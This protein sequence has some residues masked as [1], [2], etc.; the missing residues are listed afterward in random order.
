MKRR[1]RKEKDHHSL[2]SLRTNAARHQRGLC[3]W[4]GKPME[5]VTADHLVPLHA[6]GKTRPGNIVAACAPCNNE[7]HPELNQRVKVEHDK[8]RGVFA[9]IG[10]E[11]AS[12]PFA[13]LAQLK[14]S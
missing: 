3:Y 12:S 9:S 7:R 14:R 4:C 8:T 6:G 10:N 1:R 5:Q 11:T 13:V 2:K